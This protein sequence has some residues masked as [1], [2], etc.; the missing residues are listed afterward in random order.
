MILL[1]VRALGVCYSKTL[2]DGS[3]IQYRK[4]IRF[5]DKITIKT[6]IVAI[7]ERWLYLEHSMWVKDRPCSSTLLRTGVTEKAV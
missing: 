2:G 5:L 6:H 1:S 7:D 4:R 3:T